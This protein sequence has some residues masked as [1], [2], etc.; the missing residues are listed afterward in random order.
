MDEHTASLQRMLEDFYSD[1]GSVPVDALNALHGFER[2]SNSG[3]SD[4]EDELSNETMDI[5]EDTN[6]ES[7]VSSFKKLL[8]H[9][10]NIEPQN[11]DIHFNSPET[12]PNIN[13]RTSDVESDWNNATND[14]KVYDSIIIYLLVSVDS[15]YYCVIGC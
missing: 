6:S 12:P 14:A 11:A 5:E 3:H 7:I 13:D 8:C 4:S 2:L 1:L 10:N 15:V 9:P